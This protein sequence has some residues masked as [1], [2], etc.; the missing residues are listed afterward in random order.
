MVLGGQP[1][2]RVGHCQETFFLYHQEAGADA[3]ASFVLVLKNLFRIR[4]PVVRLKPMREWFVPGG[5]PGLQNRWW[6]AQSKPRWV[7]LPSTPA[8]IMGEYVRELC[9]RDGLD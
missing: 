8:F 4:V 7:R 2:G 9:R 3:L 1:P 5:A 6:V